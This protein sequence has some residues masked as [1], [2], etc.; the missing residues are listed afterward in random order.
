MV[1]MMGD[2]QLHFHLLH[3]CSGRRDDLM[4]LTIELELPG[5]ARIFFGL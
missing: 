4:E 1:D 2:V 3:F 5:L